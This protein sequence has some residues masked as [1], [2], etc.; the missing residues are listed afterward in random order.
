M[1]HIEVCPYSYFR[2][3]GYFWGLWCHLLQQMSSK[4]GSQ[5]IASSIGVSWAPQPFLTYFNSWQGHIIKRTKARQLWIILSNLVLLIFE[6]SIR[7]LLNVNLSLSQTL[8]TFLLYLRQRGYLPLIRKNCFTHMDGLV[9]YVKKGL[10]F[11]RNIS[12]KLCGIFL[13]FSTNFT[14]FM[15]LL[16]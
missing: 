11:A 15:V 14:S 12:R 2:W 9:V 8:L 1:F 16:L 7:I 6:V 10:S 13:I 5:K 3:C 4:W